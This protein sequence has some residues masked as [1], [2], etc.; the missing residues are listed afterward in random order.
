MAKEK[1]NIVLDG[2]TYYNIDVSVGYGNKYY[3]PSSGISQIIRQFIKRMYGDIKVWVRTSQFAGG[4]SVDVYL[5]NV[6]DEWYKKINDFANSF[7]MYNADPYSDY[8]K[9]KG[10]DAK[11]EDGTIISNASPYMNVRN[12][13]PWDA[14]E[15]EMTPP[16]YEEKKT[17]SLPTKKDFTKKG[18]FKDK[19]LDG[20][21]LVKDCNN[22]WKIYKGKPKTVFL[23]LLVKDKDVPPN[24]EEWANIKG[25]LLEVGFQWKSFDQRFVRFSFEELTDEDLEK[26]C[27]I[28]QVYFK[29]F[30]PFGRTAKF[31]TGDKVYW[32][33]E[34]TLIYDVEDVFIPEDENEEIRYNGYNQ[35]Q[36]RGFKNYA[37]S[38]LEFATSEQKSGQSEVDLGQFIQDLQ[39]L[40]DIE[41]DFAKKQELEQFISDLKL[42]FEI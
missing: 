12:S 29:G 33:D 40:L 17:K 10:V 30:I 31:K 3:L 23:Y 19:G 41:D 42:S 38:E 34:P 6:P 24:R 39:I 25:D 16:S 20:F 14:K 32:K 21:E 37:E 35:D 9:G 22:G 18:K 1:K 28:M 5:W 4:S 11:L 26:T 27:K 8:W 13:P 2:Y 36:K 15:K 7:G